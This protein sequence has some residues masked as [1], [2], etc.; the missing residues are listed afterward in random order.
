MT[1]ASVLAIGGHP[2]DVELGCGAAL[3]AHR[4]VGHRTAMLVMTGGEQSRRGTGLRCREQ[5]AA[6]RTLG[7]QLFWGGF[8]DCEVPADRRS[9][10]RIEEI[11]AVIDPDLVYVHAPDDAHQDHRTVAA[12]A[13]SAARRQCRILYYATPSTLRFEPTVFVDVE[14]YIDG[15]LSALAC[16]ESQ[17]NAESVWL[18]AVAAS[19]RHWGAMA[20]IGLAE[21][22]VPVRFVWDVGASLTSAEL[23]GDAGIKAMELVRRESWRIAR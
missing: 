23:S 9:I 20:R 14:P 15:K 21:A 1:V 5:E 16:H 6:A 11:I 19:A 8:V 17:V 22:F 12:A 3:L 13:V 4:A 7:A 2:D 18:D 10:D